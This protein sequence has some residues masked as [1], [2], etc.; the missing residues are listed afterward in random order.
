MN[1]E[2]E[3]KAFIKSNRERREKLA[4]KNGYS[5]VAE[6]RAYLEAGSDDSERTVTGEL[7]DM[8]IAFDTTGSM[9]SYI[10]SVKEHVKELIPKLFAQNAGLNISIVAF[11]DYC[12]MESATKFG[13]A[14]QVIDLTDNMN[15]LIAFVSSAKGTTGGDGDEF[16]ELVIKKITQ[17]TTWRSG[18]S[19]NVLFIGDC[20][21]HKVGYSYYPIVYNAQIDWKTEARNAADLNIVFDTLSCGNGALKFYKEL[22][23]ITGGVQLPFSNANKMADVLEA[24]SLAR[25]GET[26][27]AAF[28][29]KSMSSAV[30]S[31][32][33]MTAVYSMYKTVVNK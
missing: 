4:L 32:A 17:E 23:K 29:S 22:S 13:K 19:K 1:R 9:S 15:D 27:R 16:Y 5:S 12:D 20:N 26:T 33:E 31:D 18:S 8:V 3:L 28:F 7:T 14:Y 25:G 6:Y 30:T 2:N 10:N 11:G 21:P 24:T